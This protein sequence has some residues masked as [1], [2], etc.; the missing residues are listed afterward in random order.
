VVLGAMLAPAA[1]GATPIA[2]FTQS[3]ANPVVGDTVTFDSS[4]SRDPDSNGR[5]VARGWDLDNDG[6]FDDGNSVT[7][8]RKFTTAGTFTVRFGV[9]DNSNKYDIASKTVTVNAPPTASFTYAPTTPSTGQ[10]VTFTSS[11]S[12]VDGTIASRAWDLDNDGSFDD[13]SA[14]TA[15][16]TFTTPGN[17]TVRFRATDNRQ[18]ETI[19][20]QTINVANRAP[21]AGFTRSLLIP[22]SLDKITFTSTS[23]DSDGTIDKYA[24]DLDGD[25]KFDDGTTPTLTHAFSTPGDRTVRLKVTDN[26][27]AST[28]FSMAFAV[29]NRTPVARFTVS[30]I[31]P[32]AGDTITLTDASTDADGTITTANWDLD[33]DGQYDD[34]TGHTATFTAQQAGA[35]PLG[36]RVTDDRGVVATASQTI[37]VGERP[38]P[39]PG[40][41]PS[42]PESGQQT[43]DISTPVV[44]PPVPVEPPV[45][46]PVA[47]YRFLDPFPVVRLR[48]RTTGKGAR[49]TAFT[50][51][52]PHAS[53]LD[54]SCSGRGCPVK[55]LRKKITTKRKRGSV[56]IHVTRLERL[57][58]AGIEL[59]V[60]VT[61][62]DM[63]GKYTRIK[64]RG[65]AV[66]VR[67]DRCLLPG[68]TKPT[69]CP[70]V[71]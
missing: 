70:S 19:V 61:Q 30:T 54:I 20:S 46:S 41:S 16:Q 24:W 65:L 59:Q 18:A 32:V 44:P 33:N 56:T 12:D 36:L 3:P 55:K 5:I 2:C 31:K 42:E 25:Q 8:T 28:I 9:I 62:P 26:S 14:A 13:G 48:G 4:C 63:V 21:T 51:R 15:K 57:L 10:E 40:Q 17:H 58:P 43:F 47:P 6:S 50:V 52:A 68:S 38:V 66:P 11:S 64:I 35:Y 71:P 53:V 34:A 67:S 45:T 27:G 39:P 29:A 37:A 7:V 23:T 22:R 60:R 69:A 49:L 1:H